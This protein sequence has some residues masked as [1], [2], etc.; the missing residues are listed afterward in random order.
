MHYLMRHRNELSESM[1]IVKL[2]ETM[3]MLHNGRDTV[4]SGSYPLPYSIFPKL[5]L[6]ESGK[7]MMSCGFLISMESMLCAIFIFLMLTKPAPNPLTAFSFGFP[8]LLTG[9]KFALQ[10]KVEVLRDDIVIIGAAPALVWIEHVALCFSLG[11]GALWAN[12]MQDF[13]VLDGTAYTGIFV[14]AMGAAVWPFLN[15]LIYRLKNPGT[16]RPQV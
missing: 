7:R 5:Q 2:E 4:I 13:E 10:R 3:L 1:E 15:F 9:L 6:F 16:C 12:V 11:L 8:C 14:V